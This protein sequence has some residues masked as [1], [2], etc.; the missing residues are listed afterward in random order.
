[1]DDDDGSDGDGF[2]VGSASDVEPMLATSAYNAASDSG[3]CNIL[4]C[5]A[6]ILLALM[7]I[8][9]ACVAAISRTCCRSELYDD[10]RLTGFAWYVSFGRTMVGCVGSAGTAF[11]FLKCVGSF[12][13]VVVGVGAKV[14]GGGLV[15]ISRLVAVVR[16][17]AFD[18]TL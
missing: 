8:A 7:S 1:M 3:S 14:L 17:G 13:V 6:S 16:A 15:M 12:V 11:M 10:A 5:D 18:I 2:G 4:V 9:F